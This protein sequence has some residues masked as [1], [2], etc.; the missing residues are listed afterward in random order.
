MDRDPSPPLTSDPGCFSPALWRQ[1][2]IDAPFAW[3]LRRNTAA[4]E[5]ARL[6]DLAAADARLHAFVDALVIGLRGGQQLGEELDFADRG[7]VF[8]TA[9]A[10][11]WLPAARGQALWDQAV[12]MAA[13][14]DRAEELEQALY[15]RACD[16]ASVARVVALARSLSLAPASALRQAGGAVCLRLAGAAA[17]VPGDAWLAAA[18][19]ATLTRLLHLAGDLRLRAWA[20]IAAAR[21]TAAA[22]ALRRAALRAGHLFGDPGAMPAPGVAGDARSVT[23]DQTMIDLLLSDPSTPALAGGPSMPPTAAV[24]PDLAAARLLLRDGTQPQRSAAALVL[25]LVDANTPVFDITAPS[26]LQ[27]QWLA[28][29][30]APCP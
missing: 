18:D 15:H 28:T 1:L 19:A 16:T 3:W 2:L 23:A 26:G 7:A 11:L 12:A 4:D 30:C 5:D 10:G 17:G 8:V 21:Y 22:P 14:N 6:A 29:E 27:Y 25:A 9:L 24:P 13:A 20:P